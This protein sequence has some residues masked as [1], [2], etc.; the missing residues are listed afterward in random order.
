MGLLSKKAEIIY[1]PMVI[2]PSILAARITEI[3]FE[4]EVLDVARAGDS[5]LQRAIQTLEITVCFT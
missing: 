4:A 5:S 2:Q 1:D 3:G